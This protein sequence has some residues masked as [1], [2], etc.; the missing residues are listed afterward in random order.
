MKTFSFSRIA[1]LIVLV[2]TFSWA[3]A[4]TSVT[5]HVFAEVVESVSASSQLQSNVL[6]QRTNPT[7]VDFA[8]IK[9]NSGGAGSCSLIIGQA[10]V[11]NQS[12]DKYTLATQATVAGYNNTND[13][14]G[15]PSINLSC[16]PTADMLASN[17]NNLS[18]EVNVCLA[19]N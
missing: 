13:I 7:E 3:S 11:S 16:R 19:Y 2:S 17:T 18:G 12:R 6:L 8:T 10:K 4:Q 1:M 14:T 9:I 15:T 5:G